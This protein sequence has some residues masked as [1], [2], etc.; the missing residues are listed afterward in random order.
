MTDVLLFNNDAK[1]FTWG[2]AE[3]DSN[4]EARKAYIAALRDADKSSYS[5]LLKFVRS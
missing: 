4:N 5:H 2:S 3:L 1:R